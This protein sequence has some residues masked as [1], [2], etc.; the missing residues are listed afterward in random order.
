MIQIKTATLLSKYY[1]ES[2]KQVDQIFTYIE[3]MCQERDKFI[4]VLID[5]VESIANSRVSS[6][7]HREAQGSLRATN[8]LLTGL[9]RV[10]SNPN[11]IFLCSSNMP[12]SL[13]AAFLDRCGLKLAVKAPSFASQY[14]ILR[15]RIQKLIDRGVVLSEIAMPSHGVALIESNSGN[16]ELPG[17][18]L[19]RI[20]DLIN[21]VNAQVPSG[22]GISG[23]SL[24]QLPEQAP[25]LYLRQGECDLDMTLNFIEK[26]VVAQKTQGKD[27]DGETETRD[28]D[29]GSKETW[30]G[31]EVR[32][33]KRKLKFILEEE[34]DIET[35]KM[36]EEFVVALRGRGQKRKRAVVSIKQ[37]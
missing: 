21:S 7:K 1:S 16:L 31:I 29:R 4:C 28:R 3:K 26:F 36:L 30:E 2:A 5:E 13:D 23:R 34:C 22:S 6:T 35:L 32:G 8:A 27:I 11:V 9:D 15:G 25:L 10:K 24:T 12:S 18:R 19:L 37:E 17:S 14:A 20:V 33:Q